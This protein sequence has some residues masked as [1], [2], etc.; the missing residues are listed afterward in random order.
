M[1]IFATALSIGLG[2]QLVPNALVHMGS[3]WKILLT[4]GLL[5]AAFIAI[6][7]NLLL[8]EDEDDGSEAALSGLGASDRSHGGAGEQ[9]GAGIRKIAGM[10]TMRLPVQGRRRR[11]LR[12]RPGQNRGTGKRYQQARHR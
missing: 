2:L 1:L 10:V 4:S 9:A 12:P 3:T 5:P 8:P 6:I 11:L 7:L